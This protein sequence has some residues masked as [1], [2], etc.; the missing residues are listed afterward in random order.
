MVCAGGS[1]SCV[2]YTVSDEKR[3]L[4]S[5]QL[6]SASKRILRLVSTVVHVSTDYAYN[7]YIQKPDQL[8]FEHDKLTTSL[9]QLQSDQE[10]YSLEMFKST[11]KVDEARWQVKI[12]STRMKIDQVSEKIAVIK[13]NELFQ[14]YLSPVHLR[15]AQ[16]LRD[17]CAKNQ[18]VYIK[19]G[20]H[21]AM[22]DYIIP[23]E[24]QRTLAT[25]LSQTP[26][27]PWKDVCVVIKQDLGSDPHDIFA[28]IEKDPIASASLAQVHVAQGKDGKKYAVKIQHFGL[29]DGSEGD[30]LAITFLVDL[31]SKLFQ[32]YHSVI[33][34][35]S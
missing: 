33:L 32:G 4:K 6:M 1:I 8:T 12:A 30:M 13:D 27:S 21:I 34:A 25:L 28:H 24:Y 22:L 16:R 23:I 19:L 5:Q 35:F 11:N 15:S 17:M 29:Q 9:K 7:I 2:V 10:F 31:L 18:G 14:A 20:Q 26:S 3:R